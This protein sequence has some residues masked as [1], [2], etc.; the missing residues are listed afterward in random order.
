MAEDI[1]MWLR[2]ARQVLGLGLKAVARALRIAD[3]ELTLLEKFTTEVQ[4][5]AAELVQ[6][7]ED[8]GL[9]FRKDKDGSIIGIDPSPKINR[10]M[11]KAEYANPD[12]AIQRLLK[13]L[14]HV[15][16]MGYNL[17]LTNKTAG[18][19]FD[20]IDVHFP[21]LTRIMVRD[22]F[23]AWFDEEGKAG[24]GRDKGRLK[25]VHPDGKETVMNK[26]NVRQ[27]VKT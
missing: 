9:E 15:G 8:Y 20:T 3:K 11:I 13:H 25:V 21:V 5:Y 26:E 14:R 23:E 6:L 24:P 12:A 19:R 17:K 4:G 1:S 7:Y 18:S 16:G 22:R 27:F 10:L 2:A